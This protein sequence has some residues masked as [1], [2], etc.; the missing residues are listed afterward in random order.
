MLVSTADYVCRK[1]IQW[2]VDMAIADIAAREMDDSRWARAQ[3][4]FTVR[5]IG[6]CS[7][8]RSPGSV[9]SRDPPWPRLSIELSFY[10]FNHGRLQD[11]LSHCT[12]GM[13]IRY[14]HRKRMC[15]QKYPRCSP[16]TSVRRP[17]LV[18]ADVVKW[19]GCRV[20][21][22]RVEWG[23]RLGEIGG[24]DNEPTPRSDQCNTASL[25]ASRCPHFPSLATAE[26]AANP[27]LAYQKAVHCS[28][29]SQC[30]VSPLDGA[31]GSD[32]CAVKSRPTSPSSGRLL[33]AARKAPSCSDVR[34]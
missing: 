9:K 5:S 20:R 2:H 31:T 18:R 25:V 12:A 19:L 7:A 8:L 14:W 4:R 23:E 17:L 11:H 13:P 34:T 33:N 24:P 22:K 32:E 29:L 16:A 15:M 27:G 3:C 6:R 21:L 1:E 30:V 26:N 10:R 28:S